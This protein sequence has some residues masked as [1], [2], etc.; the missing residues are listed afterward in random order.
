MKKTLRT[1]ERGLITGFVIRM[2]LGLVIAG[3]VLFD[4]GAVAVNFFS[5]DQTAGS[6]AEAIAEQIATNELDPSDPRAVR[7]EA[8][9][10]A[11]E[12]G[13]KLIEFEASSSSVTIKLEKEA[14]TLIVKR[15]PAFRDWGRATAEARASGT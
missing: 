1:D 3:V 9:K 12:D 11:K 6:V 8:R 13:A 2:V 10:L 7:K 5:V 14:P 4:L 15:V